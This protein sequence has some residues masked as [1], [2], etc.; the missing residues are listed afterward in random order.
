MYQLT[1]EQLLADFS[2]RGILMHGYNSRT[3]TFLKI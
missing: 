1:R 2:F 3:K